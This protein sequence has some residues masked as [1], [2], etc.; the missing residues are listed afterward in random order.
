VRHAAGRPCLDRDTLGQLRLQNR[1]SFFKAS[2][3]LVGRVAGGKLLIKSRKLLLEQE[4]IGL[5]VDSIRR[6]PSLDK[7]LTQ[8]LLP[9]AKRRHG[10]LQLLE[11]G[12]R[13]I[14]IRHLPAQSFA[15]NASVR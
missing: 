15:L 1:L 9:A 6:P 5:V 3:D 11:F 2:L 7:L 4:G 14:D 13:P 10:G 12:D 8:F